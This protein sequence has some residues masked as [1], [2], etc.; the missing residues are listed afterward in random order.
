[1]LYIVI[2]LLLFIGYIPIALAH[3]DMW[4]KTRR[5]RRYPKSIGNALS[6]YIQK[7][8]DNTYKDLRTGKILYSKKVDFKEYFGDE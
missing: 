1:M 8:D 6:D 3:N 4:D 5:N 7:I 2:F